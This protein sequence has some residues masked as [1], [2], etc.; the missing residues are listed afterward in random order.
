MAILTYVVIALALIFI[1]STSAGIIH[2]DGENPDDEI[3]FIAS[4]FTA[5]LLSLAC[6]LV[7]FHIQ[8]KIAN[9][10]VNAE[11]LNFITRIIGG[12]IASGIS[13]VTLVAMSFITSPY[14]DTNS[15]LNIYTE[16]MNAFI[17][18][19][20]IINFGIFIFLKPRP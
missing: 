8:R 6:Y 13:T 16:A 19:F 15:L 17:I 20:I 3:I 1:W 12:L 11:Y 10:P 9:N 2:L 18:I 14:G 7:F 5:A 4:I